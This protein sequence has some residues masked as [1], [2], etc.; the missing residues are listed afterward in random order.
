MKIISGIALSLACL[1]VSGRAGNLVRN[2]SFEADTIGT[3]A[4]INSSSEIYDPTTVNS[5]A[6]T[7]WRIFNIGTPSINSF[8]GTI[9]AAGD[10][11][12]SHAMRLDIDDTGKAA[13]NDY[14]LDRDNENSGRVAVAYGNTY[15]FSFDAE[16]NRMTGGIFSLD[17]VLA[18]YDGNGNANLTGQTIFTPKLPNDAHLHSYSYTWRPSSNATTSLNIAFRP[19]SPGFV[20][21]M[22]LNN[23]QLTISKAGGSGQQASRERTAAILNAGLP[24]DDSALVAS[25]SET[26]QQAGYSVV[27]L[28]A[29]GLCSET[30][31][32]P[33]KV[34]LLV[35]PNS[36]VLPIM[37][38]KAIDGF[39][40][41]GGNLIALGAPMWQTPLIKVGNKWDTVEQYQSDKAEIPLKNPVFSFPPDERKS[42]IR[43]S[44]KP[45]NPTSYDFLPA[46]PVAGYG[47]L[48]VKLSDVMGWD[49]L[50]SPRRS[51]LFS[52]GDTFTLITVKGDGKT[53]S[54]SVEWQEKDGSR[55]I[56]V[57]A[58]TDKWCQHVLRPEDFKYWSSNPSRGFAGDKFHPENAVCIA[59]GVAET[60]TGINPGQHEYWVGPIGTAGMTPETRKTLNSLEAFAAINLQ[61]LD[62][63]SPGY[64]FF[65][66]TKTDKLAVRGDQ[67]IVTK[68]E[69]PYA[70]T[71][72]SSPRPCGGG[73]DKGR[74]WRWIPLLEAT[75]GGEWRG[76]PATLLVNTDGSYKGGIWA[77]FG[78]KGTEWYKYSDVQKLVG[79]MA[80]RMQNGIFMVDGGAN[81]Y[82]YY[83]DQSLTLGIRA[84]NV[85]RTSKT[86]TGR[87]V[88]ADADTGKPVAAKEWEMAV[89]PGKIITVSQDWRPAAWPKAGFKIT[90]ELVSDGKIIDRVS[91]EAFLWTPKAKPEFVSIKD[92]HFMLNG[93]RW[94]I[95]G[96]NYMPSSGIATED[97]TYFEQWLSAGSYDPEV[98]ERDLRHIKDMGVNA[99]SVFS[100]RSSIGAQNLIDLLRRMDNHGLKANLSLR[101]GTPM[102]FLWPQMKEII[103]HYRLKDNDTVFAYDLAWEPQLGMHDQ[104]KPLDADW[105]RWIIER[106]GSVENAERDWG[107]PV[108][109]DPSGKIT[110]PF[111]QNQNGDW[112]RMFAAYR[113]FCDTLLYKRYSAAR[114]LV[115]SIDPNHYVSFRMSMLCT[116]C[117][118]ALYLLYSSVSQ[119]RR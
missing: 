75:G 94:R 20:S 47:S 101:P 56:A 51:G 102:E 32:N 105:E 18:E 119:K 68:T 9:V 71:L 118:A 113:R 52:P 97:D 83:A 65:P 48:H 112:T 103:E 42:W 33:V 15:T 24:G 37:S 69:L 84:A 81:F 5:K 49:T 80:R 55:W 22:V 21:A 95:N 19:K 79:E 46:G 74:G 31:L 41:G 66:C 35:L 44:D 59:V 16:L 114:Q 8:K 76:N 23:V 4:L 61:A 10:A 27:K 57:V 104:R 100:Y 7:D 40:K 88:V 92:G 13:G 14:A 58:L 64:K 96:L 73:F 11:P 54:I 90:A 86:V 17:V 45:E 60:H 77:A 106:Y 63:L 109:R 72:S 108:P 116:S 117:R 82:T 70:E 50:Y 85:G 43:S 78:V 25:C 12:G 38:T 111:P 99:L 6:F 26:L 29:N 89:S 110:N 87:I 36:G 93:N 28:D 53:G 107:C 115:Q 39:L 98:I 62:T 30:T 3:Q 91:H 1:V 34:D 2:G 67:T